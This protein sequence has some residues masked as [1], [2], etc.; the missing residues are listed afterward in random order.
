MTNQIISL[1]VTEKNGKIVVSSLDVARV[2][3]KKHSHVLRDIEVLKSQIPDEIGETNFGLTSY[4]DGSNRDSKAYNLNRDGFTLLAMGFTGEKA[5]AF[6]LAYINAFNEMER[7]LSVPQNYIEAL[8]SLVAVE[9]QRLLLTAENE[10]LK[11]TLDES[12]QYYTVKR[13]AKI[14]R[15]SWRQINWRKLKMTS[16]AMGFEIHKTFDANY[17]RVNAYNIAVW[18][19]EYPDLMY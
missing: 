1:G 15:I 18:R 13:V 6:K 10:N 4:K 12:M 16:E 11:V 3:E 8:K 7:R 2:F 19:H 5:L 9:E 17:E 14:N